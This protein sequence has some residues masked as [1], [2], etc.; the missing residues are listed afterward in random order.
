LLINAQTT[1]HFL[2]GEAFGL[3]VE[4]E[5]DKKLQSHHGGKK[6]EGVSAGRFRQQRKDA[7]QRASL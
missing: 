7:G 4:E 6:Y 1:L 2:E 5:D 3:R